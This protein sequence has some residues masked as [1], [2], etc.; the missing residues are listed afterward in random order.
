MRE[1][2]WERRRMHVRRRHWPALHSRAPVSG[3]SAWPISRG[4]VSHNSQQ[5]HLWI[6]SCSGRGEAARAA[7]AAS[8]VW[9]EPR[10]TRIATRSSRARGVWPRPHAALYT[11]HARA[12]AP[13]AVASSAP[14]WRCRSVCRCLRSTTPARPTAITGAGHRQA[15]RGGRSALR[16]RARASRRIARSQ[17]STTSASRSVGCARGLG[18]CKVSD[19][20][21]PGLL[22]RP[23]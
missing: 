3:Q 14:V 7:R 11:L 15:A 2:C 1:Q 20:S 8:R 19:A 5:L 18:R 4:G 22:G 13:T 6:Y 16:R 10:S 23:H 12:G 17:P 9:C 21:T